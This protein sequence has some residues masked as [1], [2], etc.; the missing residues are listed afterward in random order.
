MAM[1]ALMRSAGVDTHDLIIEV[2]EWAHAGYDCKDERTRLTAVW[3]N[4]SGG[5]RPLV[6]LRINPDNY[7]DPS[8]GKVVTTC[9]A[10]SK[11]KLEVGVKPSKEHEWADRL[12]K[13]RQRVEYWLD[14]APEKELW[15]EQLFF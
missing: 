6:V 7:V 14:E 1:R 11:A 4:L 15:V 3:R 9:F 8:T 13:L 10:W 5:K 2:D 12:E